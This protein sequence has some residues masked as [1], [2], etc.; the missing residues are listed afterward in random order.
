MVKIIYWS[1]ASLGKTIISAPKTC[2]NLGTGI[3]CGALRAF[4][5][6]MYTKVGVEEAI[7]IKAASDACFEK[8]PLKLTPE[9]D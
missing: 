3:F 2:I 1:L 5:I 8:L 6:E 4:G 7:N 9:H